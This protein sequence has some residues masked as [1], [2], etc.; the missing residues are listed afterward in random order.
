M[1]IDIEIKVSKYFV[2]FGLINY[3]I[4]FGYLGLLF[5]LDLTDN[6]FYM[7]MIFPIILIPVGVMIWFMFTSKGKQMDREFYKLV[8]YKKGSHFTASGMEKK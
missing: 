6:Q 7:D 1:N 3:P 5:V 4:I 2:L 8:C